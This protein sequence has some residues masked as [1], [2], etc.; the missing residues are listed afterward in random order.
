MV[1]AGSGP[2]PLPVLDFFA[3]WRHATGTTAAALGDGPTAP[4]R[5]FDQIG[6]AG[7]IVI[8]N[9]GTIGFPADMANILQVRLQTSNSGYTEPRRTT[10]IAIPAIGQ[11]RYYRVYLR[12]SSE[13]AVSI[14]DPET[15]PIQD[16]S[17][18]GQINHGL[19]IWHSTGGPG[20]WTLHFQQ[21]GTANAY[22]NYIWIISTP[23]DYDT[24]YRIEWFIARTGATTFKTGIRVY[25][26]AGALLFTSDNFLNPSGVPLSTYMTAN[27]LNF[28]NVANM[29]GFNTGSNG[30]GGAD[31]PNLMTYSYQGGVATSLDTWCGPYNPSNG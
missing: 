5:K 4:T 30:L 10:G 15:H 19:W 22:P 17:S 26:S 1:R 28:F 18:A 6:G 16:G 11:T 3:D 9:P 23:L 21:S 13:T 27:D 7:A 24:T 31:W 20:K 12:V 14:A 8:V 2:A 29:A 25:D